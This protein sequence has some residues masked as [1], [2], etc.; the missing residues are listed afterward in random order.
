MKSSLAEASGSFA[1]VFC[2]TGVIAINE[3]SNGTVTHPGIA[4]TFG[5]IV[6][7]NDL[8]FGRY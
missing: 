6:R 7:G 8:C 2:S 1:L 3:F 4:I 5:L